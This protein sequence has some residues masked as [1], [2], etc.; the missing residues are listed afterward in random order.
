VVV[1][2]G[3]DEAR[4]R[5]RLLERFGVEVGAGLGPLRGKVWRIGLMGHS[6]T[7]ENV[8]ICIAALGEALA[9]QGRE[10]SVGAALSA[11]SKV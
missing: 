7:E 9:D 1:P 4:V 8:R 10:V 2:E 11:V 3:V 5:G 6:A